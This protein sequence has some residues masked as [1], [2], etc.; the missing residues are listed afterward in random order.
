[1]RKLTKNAQDTFRVKAYADTNGVLLAFNLDE[2]VRPGLLASARLLF[3][4]RQL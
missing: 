3:T 4:G 2:A 1:M